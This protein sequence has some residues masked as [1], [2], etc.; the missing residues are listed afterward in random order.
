MFDFLPIDARHDVVERVRCFF[1]D[2]GH[3]LAMA[4][5]MLGGATAE[6]RVIACALRV[7]TARRLDRRSVQDLEAIHRL[8]SLEHVGNCDRIETSFF[9][10][11]HPASAAV[12]AICRLTDQ[13]ADLLRGI[14]AAGRGAAA[15]GDPIA[16]A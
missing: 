6:Q 13:L 5:S 9:A 2:N 16:A 3:D 10:E 15:G 14:D 7:E 1:F 11:L 4:A 8:L 12:E